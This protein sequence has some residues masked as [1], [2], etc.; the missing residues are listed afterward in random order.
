MSNVPFFGKL[1]EGV[2]GILDKGF[3]GEKVSVCVCTKTENSTGLTTEL[4]RARPDAPFAGS[5]KYKYAIPDSNGAFVEASYGSDA[6]A[7]VSATFDKLRPGLQAVVGTEFTLNEKSDKDPRDPKA[8]DKVEGKLTYS[9]ANFN[10]VGKFGRERSGL[11]SAS[12]AVAAG[13]KGFT[14]GGDCNIEFKA[15]SARDVT[16]CNAG[17][18]YKANDFSLTGYIREKLMKDQQ[19]RQRSAEF[20]YLHNVNKDLAVAATFSHAFPR[21]ARDAEDKEVQIPSADTYTV[22]SQIKLDNGATLKSKIDNKALLSLSY[23]ETIRPSL[24]LTVS[25]EVDV[26]RVSAGKVGAA[27]CYGN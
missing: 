3:N 18:Q 2:E 11:N 25:G 21:L 14:V 19:S 10:V 12:V 16:A 6:K 8:S 17:A 13:H 1:T 23:Q 20:H 9:A 15:V 26:R 7:T 4:K 5:F 24:K 27:L 22:G